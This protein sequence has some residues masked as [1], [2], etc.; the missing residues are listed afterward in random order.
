MSA[1][2]SE[3]ILTIIGRVAS[4]GLSHQTTQKSSH[5]HPLGDACAH[6][7]PR[8]AS[9]ATS[10]R[11]G[12]RRGFA[13]RFQGAEPSRRLTKSRSGYQQTWQPPVTIPS[14]PN[15]VC[16]APA[17]TRKLISGG[18]SIIYSAGF[19]WPSDPATCSPSSPDSPGAGMPRSRQIFFAKKSGISR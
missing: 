8:G 14:V 18:P 9:L 4:S 19:Y 10:H 12:E 7:V 3:E 1:S 16:I 17:R 11:K 6:P 15:P 5:G 13:I 2:A